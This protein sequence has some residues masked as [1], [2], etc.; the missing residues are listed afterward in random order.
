MS[1]RIIFGAVMF[2]IAAIAGWQL[3]DV[4]LDRAVS[5]APA[6]WQRITTD[7]VGAAA[8]IFLG[9]LMFLVEVISPEKGPWVQLA[10]LIALPALATH[11]YRRGIRDGRNHANSDS[12][13]KA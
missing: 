9:A 4:A 1:F 8:T 10:A 5:A 11:V 13:P 6:D 12:H 2:V 7:R 3:K